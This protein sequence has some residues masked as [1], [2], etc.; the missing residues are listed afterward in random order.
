MVAWAE[1]R[2]QS[3]R[4]RQSQAWQR[5]V[6]LHEARVPPRNHLWMKCSAKLCLPYSQGLLRH[7]GANLLQASDWTPQQRNSRSNG[8]QGELISTRHHPPSGLYF[9]TCQVL[10]VVSRHNHHN[11][12]ACLT[13]VLRSLGQPCPSSNYISY[14]TVAFCLAFPMWTSLPLEGIVNV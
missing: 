8:P 7:Q 5:I 9:P 11:P 14:M 3:L 4:Y 6:S 13:V 10:S 2:R 1:Y 12:S